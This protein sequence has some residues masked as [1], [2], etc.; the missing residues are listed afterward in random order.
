MIRS[1]GTP[2][3]KFRSSS[4]AKGNPWKY[5][6]LLDLNSFPEATQASLLDGMEALTEGTQNVDHHGLGMFAIPADCIKLVSSDAFALH[7]HRND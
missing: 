5:F 6:L 4:S 2:T 7:Q 1:I 3:N